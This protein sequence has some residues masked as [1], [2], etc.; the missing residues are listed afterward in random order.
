MTEE[1]KIMA[2]QLRR[3]NIFRLTDDCLK[4]TSFNMIMHFVKNFPHEHFELMLDFKWKSLYEEKER[5][6]FI[7][8]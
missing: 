5:E 6:N 3:R 1:D 2:E 8:F 4:Y 7:M